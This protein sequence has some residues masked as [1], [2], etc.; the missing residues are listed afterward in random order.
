MLLFTKSFLRLFNKYIN[1]HNL[2]ILNSRDNKSN[3]FYNR[4]IEVTLVAKI[5][6]KRKLLSDS[7]I[8]YDTIA[9]KYSI[10]IYN[11]VK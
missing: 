9:Y 6:K 8:T 11:I 3:L 1:T 4:L 2:R 10:K 5:F 7:D